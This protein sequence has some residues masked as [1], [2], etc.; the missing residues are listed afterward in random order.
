MKL[1]CFYYLFI[2]YCFLDIKNFRILIFIKPN[3]LNHTLSHI[4]HLVLIKK[5]Y[6]KLVCL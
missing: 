1:S 4:S 6:L 5:I 3:Y 2:I